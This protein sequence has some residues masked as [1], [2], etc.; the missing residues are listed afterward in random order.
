MDDLILWFLFFG[1]FIALPVYILDRID[2]WYEA[3]Y[4]S[5]PNQLLM[6]LL[7]VV[8]FISIGVVA[9]KVFVR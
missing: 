3:K 7:W 4:G 6:I 2:D 8:W 9:I 5:R 1:F